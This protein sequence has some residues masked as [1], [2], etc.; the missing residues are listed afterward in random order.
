MQPVRGHPWDVSPTEATAIQ[1]GLL[2]QLCTDDLLGEVQTVAGIDV[3]LRQGVARAAIVVLAFPGLIPVE[4]STAQRE[5]GFPYIPGLLTFR[6]GPVI[7]DALEGLSIEPDVLIFDG[8][9]MAHPRRMGLATHMG[10]LLDHPAIGCAKSRLCGEY[11]MPGPAKGDH[12]YLR[13]DGEVIGAALRTRA[14]VS[15]VFVSIGHKVDLERAMDCVLRCC[16]TYRL[17]ETTR[18][19]HRVAGGASAPGPKK[20]SAGRKNVA[21]RRA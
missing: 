9:G 8:Q 2:R 7:L 5:I 11:E 16:P 14:K 6:E 13:H 17:P 15:P 4:Q 1:S 12:S 10:I 3:G 19:A 18:W 20:R 21:R